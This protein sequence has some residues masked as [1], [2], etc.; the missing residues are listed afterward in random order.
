MDSVRPNGV[1][2]ELNCIAIRPVL[3]DYSFG[4]PATSV[5]GSLNL[6]SASTI[7]QTPL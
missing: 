1:I 6:Q 7:V 4:H 3:N 2:S 5:V